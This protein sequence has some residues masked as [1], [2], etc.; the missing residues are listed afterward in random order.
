MS[1]PKTSREVSRNRLDGRVLGG[2]LFDIAKPPVLGVLYHRNFHSFCVRSFARR[3]V[4]A[5]VVSIG[6]D[7]VSSFA[8]LASSSARSLPVISLWLGHQDIE[9]WSNLE[10]SL[11]RP[12]TYWSPKG[13][14]PEQSRGAAFASHIGIHVRDITS[15][16]MW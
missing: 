13:L 4:F 2:S 9:R 6:A 1:R 15:H 3:I 16:Y 8:S 7:Q 14:V 5:R 11:A 10:G 12:T